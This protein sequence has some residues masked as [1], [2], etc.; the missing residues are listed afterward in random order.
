MQSPRKIDYLIISFLIHWRTMKTLF[1]SSFAK[2]DRP[3]VKFLHL[4]IKGIQCYILIYSLWHIARWKIGKHENCRWKFNIDC[5]KAKPLANN[6]CG[7]EFNLFVQAASLDQYFCNLVRIAVGRWSSVFKISLSVFSDTSWD[8]NG[9]ASVSYTSTEVVDWGSFMKT[10]QTSFVVLS[11]IRIIS[12][13]MTNV[14]PGQFIN[15]S[16]NY[17]QATWLSH[18][19]SWEIAMGTSTVPISLNK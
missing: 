16:F 13:D 19:Q 1:T 17:C 2:N 3:K 7:D 8:T 10:S 9:A 5:F 6:S 14:M 11:F 18:G 12:L 15:G 4:H